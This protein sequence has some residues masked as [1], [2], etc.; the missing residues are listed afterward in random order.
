MGV[1]AL[2]VDRESKAE[3]RGALDVLRESQHCWK[4]PAGRSGAK[5][6][7]CTCG[8]AT[9]RRWTDQFFQ[10]LEVGAVQSAA[11]YKESKQARYKARCPWVR[12]VEWARRRVK[13]KPG[14]NSTQSN[15]DHY[16]ERGIVCTLNA[17]QARVL[18]ERD[19]AAAMKRPSLDRKE[20]TL[21]YTFENCRFIEFNIN[22]RL[23]H[24]A[25]LRA[26]FAAFI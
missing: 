5:K 10:E 16:T 22:V 25:G 4:C 7:R 20:A 21:G 2:K 18:W 19:G 9:L 26:K 1:V 24:D 15:P 11:S 12:Y 23:P 6:G 3:L 17:A 13:G 14:Q 8:M